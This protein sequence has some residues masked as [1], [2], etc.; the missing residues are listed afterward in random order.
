MAPT[1]APLP[2]DAEGH[3]RV[4][5]TPPELQD[6]R[7]PTVDVLPPPADG[8][9]TSAVSLVP[10][11]VLA[12]S[13]WSPQCPV[14]AADLRYATVTFRGFDGAAHIGEL[15][16][17]AS[18]ATQVATA[19]RELHAAGFPIEQMRVTD[20]AEL[21]APATGDGNNTSAFVCRP[22]AA[23]R[24]GRRTLTGSPSTSTRSRTPTGGVR[25]FCRSWRRPTSAEPTCDPA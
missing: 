21:D 2:L 12:R 5:P 10:P 6:R 16:V 22:R 11:D 14:A 20:R 25:Q 1:R 4:L 19:F 8:A 15:L 13:T 3:P 24:R 18:G 7:L 17:N 9:F 23:S